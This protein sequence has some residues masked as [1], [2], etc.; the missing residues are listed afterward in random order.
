MP[1]A[2]V[3]VVIWGWLC[4]SVSVHSVR[5]S[6]T[7]LCS[8]LWVSSSCGAVDLIDVIQ[9]RRRIDRCCLLAP[10]SRGAA[11]LDRSTAP[12]S[13]ICSAGVMNC[14]RI[15]FIIPHWIRNWFSR[16]FIFAGKVIHV[17]MIQ[18]TCPVFLFSFFFTFNVK[19][20]LCKVIPRAL[21]AMVR[22]FEQE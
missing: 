13:V 2:N 16:N 19:C 22:R 4:C 15:E 14:Q 7:S 12:L 17:A 10:T 21:L 18:E 1:L 20:H 3:C 6:L 8:L 5:C 9:S 11:I